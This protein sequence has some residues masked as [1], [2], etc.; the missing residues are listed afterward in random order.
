MAAIR[1]LVSALYAVLIVRVGARLVSGYSLP[2]LWRVVLV[3]LAV[4]LAV[5]GA[6]SAVPQVLQNVQQ[7]RQQ[8]QQQKQQ[9]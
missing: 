5:A 2:S 6:L 9:Q 4:A 8:Q 7:Q 1:V 3:A